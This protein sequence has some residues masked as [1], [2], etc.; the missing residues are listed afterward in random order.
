[1]YACMF[2]FRQFQFF[3]NGSLSA[4]DPD[5]EDEEDEVY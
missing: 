1:M 5:K 4:A 2:D 3:L